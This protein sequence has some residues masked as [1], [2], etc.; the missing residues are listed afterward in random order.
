MKRILLLFVMA[1]FTGLWTLAADI[2]PEQALQQAR[3]FMLN[4]MQHQGDSRWHHHRLVPQQ[5]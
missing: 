4:K 5:H 2:T 1:S 3:Q